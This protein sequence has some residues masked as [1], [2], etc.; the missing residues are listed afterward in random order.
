VLTPDD[1][2]LLAEHIEPLIEIGRRPKALS[3][4][5]HYF[6]LLLSWNRRINLIS[7]GDE[8]RVIERHALDSLL[9]IPVVDE[10]GGRTVLDLGSGAGLPGIPLKILRPRVQ[11]ALLDSRRLKTIFL[12]RATTELGLTGVRVW[13]GRAEA[14]ADLPELEEPQLESTQPEPVGSPSIGDLEGPTHRPR[15]DVVTSRAVASLSE[16][17]RWVAPLVSPGGHLLAYKGSRVDSEI[18]NWRA[19]PE[20][21]WRL[22][23]IR[24]ELRPQ[25]HLV[26]LR[27]L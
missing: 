22:L 20:Q 25:T 13:R 1:R 15:F 10:V 19:R 8:A 6:G 11:I 18:E 24:R 21:P 16:V 27:R 4:L 26:I 9:V 7:R 14:L 2:R 12:L 5:E 3:Q 23:E 17:A